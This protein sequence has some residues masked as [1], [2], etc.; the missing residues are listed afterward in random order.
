MRDNPLIFSS[1]AVKRTKA[2]AARD[3]GTTYQSGAPPPEVKEHKGNLL[4]HNLW[5]NETDSVHDMRVANTDA[6]SHMAKSVEK[7]LQEAERGNKM[8][9][10]EACLQQ[11]RPSSPICRLAGWTVGGGGDGNLEEFIQSPGHQ[12]E[13]NLIEDMWIRQE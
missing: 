2:T 9:Y 3:V 11:H 5:Q 7:C 10:F 6:K 4:I 1:R 8:M 12:V 13:A